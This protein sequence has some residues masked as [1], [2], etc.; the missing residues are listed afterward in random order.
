MLGLRGPAAQSR[1][2]FGPTRPI[3]LISTSGYN[4]PKKQVPYLVLAGIL[5]GFAHVIFSFHLE[6][7]PFH[8]AETNGLRYLCQESP[9]SEMRQNVLWGGS[10]SLEHGV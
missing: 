8:K 1:T 7:P 6:M 4:P 10:R 2:I 9:T 3:A 5:C